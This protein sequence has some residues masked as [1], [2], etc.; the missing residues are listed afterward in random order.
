MVV[1]LIWHSLFVNINIKFNLFICLSQNV[2]VDSLTE[3][4]EIRQVHSSG[5]IKSI[6][7]TTEAL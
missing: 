5:K 3:M 4:T 6:L 2:D 7:V 1:Y